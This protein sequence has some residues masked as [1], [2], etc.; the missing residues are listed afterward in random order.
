LGGTAIQTQNIHWIS[1]GRTHVGKVRKLNEDAVLDTPAKGLW[2]VA[3]GMGGHAAGDY[4]SASLVAAL[5][6]IR[7]GLA[8]NDLIAETRQ[9]LERINVQLVSEGRQRRARIIGSTIVV[10][11]S[12]G[13]EAVV[14]WAGDSRLYRLGPRRLEL[15]TK[16]HSR[17]QELITSGKLQ[18]EEAEQHP[19][20]NIITRAVGVSELLDLDSQRF[21]VRAGD[22]FLL[23]SDGLSRYL[24]ESDIVTALGAA[25]CQQACDRLIDAALRTPARD[26]VTHPPARAT[27]DD[28]VVRTRLNPNP[29]GDAA[30]RTDDGTTLWDPDR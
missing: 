18:P 6:E 11:L 16:D 27:A 17:I 10:L 13:W 1:A 14:M 5:A 26:N 22:T 21:E 30:T 23:C 2:A 7:D 12:N 15:V 4:A 9:R 29:I 24:G 25:S 3:D 28:S 19:E 20:A 8:L